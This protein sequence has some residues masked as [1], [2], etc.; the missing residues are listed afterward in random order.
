MSQ[1]RR[2]NITISGTAGYEVGIQSW[3]PSARDTVPEFNL[4]GS[5]TLDATGALN[6]RI[7]TPAS[8]GATGLLE[9]HVAIRDDN[10]QTVTQSLKKTV[11]ASS[12]YVAARA[13]GTQWYWKAGTLQTIDLLVV[14]PDGGRVAAVPVGVT[15]I[16]HQWMR[17]TSSFGYRVVPDTVQRFVVTSARDS[18]PVAFTPEHDGT[19]EVSMSVRDALGRGSVT[20]VIRWATSSPWFN[21]PALN[22]FQLRVQPQRDAATRYSLGDSAVFT[23]AS[24]YDD[25]DAWITLEREA[26][27]EQRVMRVKHGEN[28]LV[29]PI[30]YRHAPSI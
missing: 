21:D 25:A 26:I 17:D 10:N 11:Y 3:W 18:V 20:N 2:E 4:R 14:R 27:L 22:R 16:R 7:P 6:M 5:D 8:F 29:V 23:F 12:Y 24:P 19:Y 9:I 1:A 28:R 15:I 13:R 30:T